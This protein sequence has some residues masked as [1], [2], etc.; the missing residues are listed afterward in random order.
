MERKLEAVEKALGLKLFIWQKTFIERGVFRQYGETTA[1]ILKDLLDTKAQPLDYA[2]PCGSV[3][4][5][6]YR[7]ETRNIKE[8]LDN[9]GIA[10]RAVFF[11]K[12]EKV[13]YM[14]MKN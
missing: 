1:R 13:A 2:E 5:N 3:R 14:K 9:A 12:E 10:T 11:T 4:E 8:K 7:M 6:F